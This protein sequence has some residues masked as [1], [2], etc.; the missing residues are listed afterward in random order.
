MSDMPDLPLRY[1][2]TAPR[3]VTPAPALVI[4]LHGYGSNEEDLL[5][6][7]P[8]FPD[9][10]RIVSL[11]APFMLMPGSNCWYELDFTPNG[12]VSDISQA[13]QSLARVNESIDAAITAFECDPRR[14]FVVGFSQGGG[15]AGLV[16]M[17]RHDLAGVAVLSGINPY[18]LSSTP[19]DAPQCPMLVVHGTFDEV[20][21]V[22]IGHSTR[23]QLTDAGANVR[24]VEYPIGHT[25]DLRVIAALTRFLADYHA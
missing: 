7:A 9:T 6:L 12:I 14:V 4:L 21:P 1:E 2:S 23:D 16:A 17:H 13:Q 11:R 19:L 15:L 25:V 10:C 8:Y 20:V 18:G 24:Y 5:Q 22:H 3:V